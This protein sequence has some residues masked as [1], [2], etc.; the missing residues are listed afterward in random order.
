MTRLAPCSKS[1]DQFFTEGG[2]PGSSGH[3]TEYFLSAKNGQSRWILKRFDLDKAELAQI[4]AGM[5]ALYYLFGKP[6]SIPKIY[7]VYRAAQDDVPP[8]FFS[9]I[10][11]EFQGFQDLKSYFSDGVSEEK[12][13]FL[14]DNGFPQLCALSYFFEEDDLHKKNIGIADGKVVRVDFDMSAYSIVGKPELRGSRS[15]F[16]DSNRFDEKFKVTAFDIENFPK[17]K[18]A[19]P[20][21]FPTLHRM[22]ASSN[23]YSVQEVSLFQ[24][25]SKNLRFVNRAYLSFLKLMIVPDE[26]FAN[27][28]S[29]H[30][31]SVDRVAE[32][33]LH[34][35]KKRSELREVLLKT[36]ECRK[37]DVFMASLSVDQ[38]QGLFFEL[39]NHN[40]KNKVNF[41]QVNL[42]KV[43]EQFCQFLFDMLKVDFQKKLFS[44]FEM[45][46]QI[47]GV[48]SVEQKASLIGIRENLLKY[49]EH[50]M[51]AGLASASDFSVFIG[52]VKVSLQSVHALF[53]EPSDAVSGLFTIIMQKINHL[54]RLYFASDIDILCADIDDEA[55]FD[56]VETPVEFSVCSILDEKKLARDIIEWMQEKENTGVLLSIVRRT[57]VRLVEEQATLTARIS[58]GFSSVAIGATSFFGRR[59]NAAGPSL[60]EQLQKMIMEFDETTDLFYLVFRVLSVSGGAPVEQAKDQI[61]FELIKHYVA[62]FI[63][64]PQTDQMQVDP[65]LSGYLRAQDFCHYPS[66]TATLCIDAFKDQIRPYIA[67]YLE[68]PM[69]CAA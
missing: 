53:A 69:L 54:E 34:F 47:A 29:A 11:A 63:A 40:E 49:Y 48:L 46:Q 27:L 37:F 52:K 35:L 45:S 25:L 24:E 13:T 14:V 18:D 17:L 31:G 33:R 4:E 10:S 15:S 8:Q 22:V 39:R 62:M 19:K 23:G 7:A 57:I 64:K 50:L 44:Y 26:L 55:G 20:Y 66:D 16:M 3:R 68:R 56:L 58:S 1:I 65:V 2:Q 38:V 12:L 6:G 67:S 21:Y 59:L 5:A 42:N 28:L 51:Q 41:Q 61:L 9:S 43:R 60:I 30:I 36:D 32:L